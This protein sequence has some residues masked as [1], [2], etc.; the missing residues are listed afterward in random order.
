MER[1]IGSHRSP[2]G[3]HQP[4][5]PVRARLDLLV[6]APLLVHIV[7]D[8]SLRIP[9]DLVEPQIGLVRRLDVHIVHGPAKVLL[10]PERLPQLSPQHLQLRVRCIRP[11]VHRVA[12][13]LLDAPPY[14][15]DP[16]RHPVQILESFRR[17]YAR[18][19][20]LPGNGILGA[21]QPFKHGIRALDLLSEPAYP[22]SIEHIQGR[23]LPAHSRGYLRGI[24][25][26]HGRD[27]L[28]DG[29]GRLVY[30]I[31]R[32]LESAAID[33][34]FHGTMQ[35]PPC[36]H[37]PFFPFFAFLFISFSFSLSFFIFNL[38]AATTKA[39]SG[40]S[41]PRKTEGNMCSF[42]RA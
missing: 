25:P 21:A 40:S 3:P 42:R 39:F 4:I 34:R 30:G 35:V 7:P 2:D 1:G 37:R 38:T 13:Y 14:A 20:R 41:S 31:P 23:G 9:Y 33:R 6:Q 15:V 11:H 29:H 16:D 19:V 12:L 36:R 32:R 24:H 22:A 26:V 10:L 27:Q 18:V 8:M 28:L 5:R 17:E